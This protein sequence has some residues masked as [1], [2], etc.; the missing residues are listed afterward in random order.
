MKRT[1]ETLDKETVERK[2]REHF[3][4]KNSAESTQESEQ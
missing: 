1:K 3:V 2:H 4:P